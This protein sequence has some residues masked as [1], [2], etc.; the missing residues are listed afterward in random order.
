MLPLGAVV[1][2]L[3][4]GSAR[5][6]NVFFSGRNWTTY[7]TQTAYGGNQ[8][9]YNAP[10]ANTGTMRG[11]FNDAGNENDAVM[12]TAL[13]VNVGDKVSYDWQITD[14]QRDLPGAFGGLSNWFAD[15]STAF[16]SSL[17]PADTPQVSNRLMFVNND[18]LNLNWQQGGTWEDGAFQ[19]EWR[20]GGLELEWEFTGSTTATAKVYKTSDGTLIDTFSDT[21]GNISDIVGFRAGLWD[22]EQTITLSNFTVTPV[23][24]PAGVALLGLGGAMMLVRRKR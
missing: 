7:D 13:T 19:D 2:L 16:V 4:T 22:S 10:D 24:E 18:R 21:F 15:A 23:P 8:I 12:I 5:G 17:D 1:L 6:G 14:E 11:L 9:E 3:L 20:F